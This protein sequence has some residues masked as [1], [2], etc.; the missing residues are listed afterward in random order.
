[1]D[2]F[3]NLPPPGNK[4]ADHESNVG[5]YD[6]VSMEIKNS[7]KRTKPV[8]PCKIE[9]KKTKVDNA[10]VKAIVTYS[11]KSYIAE[12]QGERE[13]MQDAALLLDD[14]TRDFLSCNCGHEIKRASF[15]GVFDGHGGSRASLF[16]KEN[17]FEYIKKHFP[18]DP[19]EKFDAELKKRLTKAFKE[20]DDAFLTK[21]SRETPNWRDG[22]TASCVLALND[23]LYVAN[24]GDSKTVL[25]RKG[26]D[27]A[28]SILPLTKDHSPTEYGERQRIQKA[29]GFVRESRVQGVLEVS[30]AFGDARFKKY[31][32]CVPD[33]TKSTL[34]DNDKY[35]I[36]ACD[37]LWKGFQMQEAVNYIDAI[38]NDTTIENTDE[39]YEKACGNVASEAIR[40]GSSDNVTVVIIRILDLVHNNQ[41]QHEI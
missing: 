20:T 12:R 13:E 10:P 32:T 23:I 4:S 38:L 34:T 41:R 2:I 24:I 33:V 30:R 19:V 5:L 17:L 27:G 31:V 25:V 39:R 28:S 40:R 26:K 6:G 22:S 36:I 3:D 14:C 37:G 11:L 7:L 18:K 8:E 15:Y 21:A 1:M 16:A 9:G 29:G 35:L